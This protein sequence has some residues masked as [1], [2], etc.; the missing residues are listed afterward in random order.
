MFS[1]REAHEPRDPMKAAQAGMKASLPARF[2]SEV[3]IVEAPEGWLLLLD[4]KPAKTPARHPLAMPGAA[5]G[6]A[7]AQEWRAQERVI[8]PAVMPLTRLL[9]TALDGVAKNAA[10]VRAEIVRFASSDLICYRAEAPDALRARQAQAWD[11][12]V[13]WAR[14]VLGARLVLAAGVMHVS[15]PDEALSA[16]AAAV[17]RFDQPLSLAALASVNALTGSAVIALALAHGALD[18]DAAWAVGHI[19]EDYQTEVWGSD[20]EAEQRLRNRRLDFD[21]A[22][23][24]LADRSAGL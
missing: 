2:Y 6:E 13:A 7:L 3:A 17:G 10:D 18:A 19:D 11:P 16:I 5:L 4:G 22:A 24:V 21:A 15:Q 14:D 8:N 9:N 23:L 20:E 12:L 1:A